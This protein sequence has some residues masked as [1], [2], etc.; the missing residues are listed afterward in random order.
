MNAPAGRRI[1][2]CADDFGIAPGVDAAIIDLLAQRRLSAVSC[3]TVFPEFVSDAAELKA[4][5]NVASLGVHLTL[6][7]DRPLGALMRAAYLR[8]LDL[9]AIAA[10]IDDQIERFFSAM[11][12][13]PDFF[14]GHQ[15]IHVL[16]GIR[17]I[18]IERAASHATPVRALQAPPWHRLANI[19]SPQKALGLSLMGRQLARELKENNLAANY[20]FGGVRSFAEREP[21][22]ALFVRMLQN[23]ADNALI[24]CHPGL[25]DTTLAARD[26][27]TT[28]QDEYR[29]LAS[30]AFLADLSDANA[31]LARLQDLHLRSAA[32]P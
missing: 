5:A 22:R 3:M 31:T 19:P 9:T 14:D 2:L 27:L 4:F 6:T 12:R 13:K 32:A 28:R 21:Y 23:T 8:Q 26:S 15:H 30:D 25:P 17:K 24:M 20:E 10:E 29:Y 7:H 18:V 16:P 11:G 1:I